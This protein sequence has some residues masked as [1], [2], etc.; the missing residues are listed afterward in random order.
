MTPPR[1][2][3]SAGEASG[4]AVGA[5][6]VK[7][8]RR[9]GFN[10][11][12]F[13]VGARKLEQAGAQLI[14]DSSTWGA[15]GVYQA[16][17]MAPKLLIGARGVSKWLESKVPD[18]VIAIDF[19]YMNVRLCR[20]AKKL[21]SKV[22]YFMPPGSWRKDRQGSDL[23]HVADK[24][25]TPFSWSADLLR[26]AGANVEWVG[27]PA[28]QMAGEAC[29][30]ERDV[31]AIL[32]GS[33]KHEIELN[34]PVF[35]RA[36]ALLGEMAA[37]PVIVAAPNADSGMLGRLWNKHCPTKAEVSRAGP[38]ETLKRSRAA[39]ICTGTATLEAA[40]CRTP[41]V[42]AYVLD[43]LMI[44]EA[45]LIRLKVDFIALPNILLEKHAVPELYHP[46][47]SPETI[48]I[49]TSK[50]LRDSAERQAQ[51]DD[52]EEIVKILGPN[53]AITRTAKM[54]L[55]LI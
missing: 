48:A 37:K 10:G 51:L 2:L 19:G 20:K 13:A 9:Q 46:N 11:E 47:A 14:A 22:L 12:V 45:K 21:A 6:L 15:L 38:Y 55:E 24:I 29:D 41:M 1:V 23:A 43:P 50:L 16:L 31:L 17:K 39:I 44:L 8:M 53:D 3:I 25:A 5:E 42:A 54:A 35:A 28:V 36:V 30:G 26:K 7:E 34:L 4:D 18:L 40:V 49:E 32:P 27:H 33:R 52:F